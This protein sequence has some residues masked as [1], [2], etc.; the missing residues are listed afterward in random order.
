M[1]ASGLIGHRSSTS[2]VTSG[3]ASGVVFRSVFGVALGALLLCAPAC[4]SSKSRDQDKDKGT[5]KPQPTQVDQKQP[6]GP[7]PGG[8]LR[9]RSE[10]P[11]YLNPVIQTQFNRAALLIFEGLVGLDSRL[12]PVPRLAEKW[13]LS[14]DGKVLTFN[15]RKDVMW[16]DDKPFTAK[17][18]AFTFKAIREVKAQ[19]LWKAY[20]EDVETVETPDDHTVVVK[21]K[22]PY[23]PALV[24]WTVGILPMH[25]YSEGDDLTKSK[26]NREAVG[27]GPYKL[28]RWE[29]GQRM[30][31]HAN[32]KWWHKEDGKTLPYIDSIE[33]LFNISTD[34]TIEALDKGDIDFAEILD[35]DDW[36]TR[37]Q[38]SEFR[39]DFE[40]S[41]VS[42][43]YFRSI[44]WNVSKPHLADKR[45]RLALTHALNRSRV[46][47]DVLFRSAQA[48]SGPFFPTMY[49][50]DP[51]IAPW[52]FDLEKAKQLLDEA[53]H[54]AKGDKGTRFSIDMISLKSQEHP[55]T[56]ASIGIFRTD[57][58][59]IGIELK[60]THLD[61]NAFNE[62][63]IDG[64]YD[65]VY[66]GWL[67]DI[68]DPDPT[69][70][71]HSRMI[72]RRP[73]L[74]SLLQSRGR[75]VARGGPGPRRIAT[76]A[77]KSTTSS[78]P[79]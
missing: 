52:S 4:T 10:E 18:V 29:P 44:A 32:R 71:L 74:R 17:D 70:L 8:H 14:E 43:A 28:A 49:G 26:Y 76:N 46:I 13:S 73:Q 23:G 6:T 55:V 20:M 66:F 65:A 58:Q 50:A 60:M 77:K 33:I 16:H 12:E 38:T 24:A 48:M 19:T 15:L 21:Y 45:V 36:T 34:G 72:A 11:R 3:G 56:H 7:Q 54:K 64:K 30:V 39:E 40:V 61:S 69:A 67:S 79:R 31:L 47:D 37:V 1:N 59:K 63:V 27:S 62:R 42:E 22:E 53:G 51:S 75:Q 57:L 35:I 25:L 5:A 78:T 41:D 68:P 9:L 2:T